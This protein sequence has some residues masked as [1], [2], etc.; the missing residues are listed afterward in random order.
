MNISDILWNRLIN[1][2]DQYYSIMKVWL[3]FTPIVSIRH[4]DDLEV[5]K[6]KKKK[7]NSMYIHNLK[8]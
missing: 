1:Y 5:I 6:Y 4:P 3:L 2:T 8:I 7:L